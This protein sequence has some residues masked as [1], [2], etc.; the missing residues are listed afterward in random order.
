MISG[1]RHRLTVEIN[2]QAELGR[3]LAR[4]QSQ[5]SAGKRI[6]A[7]SDDPTAA[8]QISE[9]ARAQAKEAAWIRNL[10]AA[11]ALSE[12]ADTTLKGVGEDLDRVLVLLTNGA[13]GTASA[14][15]R[16]V[17]AKEIDS[18]AD[19]I[20]AAARAR[21]P[22]GEELFGTGPALEIPVFAGGTI[23]PVGRRADVFGN[24][25][26]AGGPRDLVAIVRGAAAAIR[27]P[28]DTLRRAAMGASLDEMNKATEHLA[29]AHADQGVRAARIEALREQLRD[30]SLQLEEQKGVLEGTDYLEAVPRFEALKLTLEA[31]QAAF[32][33]ISQKS[34]FDMIR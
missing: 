8:A 23:V 18:I 15:N 34:L 31:A 5:L 22:R 33:R 21:D 28:D 27:Q 13:N 2:R 4:V 9:M 25:P 20:E 32:A 14:A 3:E 7:P 6:Q 1:T 17:I 30:S 24:V 10:D 16:E 29:A 11:E 19:A 26:T 12:R